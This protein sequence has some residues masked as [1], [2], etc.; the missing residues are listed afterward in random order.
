M[1][2]YSDK[3][4]NYDNEY[5]NNNSDNDHGYILSPKCV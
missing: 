4:N 1:I 3:N 5:D 2:K